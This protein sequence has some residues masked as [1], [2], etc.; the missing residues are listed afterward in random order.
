[1]SAMGMSPSTTMRIS[2]FVPMYRAFRMSE[3]GFPATSGQR[4]PSMA[5]RASTSAN[6]V[7]IKR[8]LRVRINGGKKD[9]FC[10]FFV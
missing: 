4:M 10:I 5:P 6:S 8:T 7:P 9:V 2:N 1:M 3:A